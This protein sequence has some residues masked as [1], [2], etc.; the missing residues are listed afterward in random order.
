M[1]EKLFRNAVKIISDADVEFPS[2][3][4]NK[5][6]I[7]NRSVDADSCSSLAASIYNGYSIDL[8]TNRTHSCLFYSL[9]SLE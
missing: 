5:S 4:K 7:D 1:T 6:I 2:L 3:L 9:S 8:L